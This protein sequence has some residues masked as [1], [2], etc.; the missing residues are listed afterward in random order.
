[1]KCARCDEIAADVEFTLTGKEVWLCWHH[2][3][4]HYKYV[5]RENIEEAD[6]L[7]KLHKPRYL[8]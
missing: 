7:T 4:L 3:G 1:M 5:Y 2:L 6:K 8:K